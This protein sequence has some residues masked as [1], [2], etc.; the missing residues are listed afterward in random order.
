M[1][2]TGVGET[3]NESTR[4]RNPPTR[5]DSSSIDIGGGDLTGV[6][7]VLPSSHQHRQRNMVLTVAMLWPR[8]LCM[9]QN[10][11]CAIAFPVL[12]S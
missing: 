9:T 3:P 5:D 12:K 2:L 11:M 7:E 6:V 1:D 8:F 4:E 10:S